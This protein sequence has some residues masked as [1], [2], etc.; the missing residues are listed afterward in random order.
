MQRETKGSINVLPLI[1]FLLQERYVAS[2]FQGIL[3]FPFFFSDQYHSLWTVIRACNSE[4]DLFQRSIAITFRSLIKHSVFVYCL[5]YFVF[6]NLFVVFCILMRM[7]A[8]SRYGWVV[9]N[10]VIKGNPSST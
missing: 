6:G 2:N 10:I 5:L 1:S 9:Y 4:F 3:N 7:F 8:I